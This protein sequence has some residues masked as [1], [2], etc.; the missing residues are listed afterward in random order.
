MLAALGRPARQVVP[1]TLLFS[2]GVGQ[3][4]VVFA[5]DRATRILATGVGNPFGQRLAAEET[6]LSSWN[7]ELCEE[8]AR[9]L[10]VAPGGHTYFVFR[11]ASAGLGAV[12]VSISP[13]AACGL[14]G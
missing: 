7:I 10:L 6:T 8:P 3:I 12:G 11:N 14:L 9:I 1:G 13:V 2:R 4:A 5:G